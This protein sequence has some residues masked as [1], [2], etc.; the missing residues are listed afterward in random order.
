MPRINSVVKIKIT[1]H[2][3]SCGFSAIFRCDAATFGPDWA[4]IGK[5]T[6]FLVR[7]PE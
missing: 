5:N 6:W 3:A 1:P 2:A 4:G 7:E